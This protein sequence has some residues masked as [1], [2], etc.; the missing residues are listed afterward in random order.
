[1]SLRKQSL[2]VRNKVKEALNNITGFS[3]GEYYNFMT[4]CF[5]TF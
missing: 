3:F 1:M 4:F 2:E 5:F